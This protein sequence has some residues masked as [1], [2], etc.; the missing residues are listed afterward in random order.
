MAAITAALST[1]PET[2]T[3][4]ITTLSTAT[5]GSPARDCLILVPQPPGQVMP[6]TLNTTGVVAGADEVEPLDTFDGDSDGAQPKLMVPHVATR[7]IARTESVFRM[8]LNS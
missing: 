4:P 5:P 7:A 1:S 6:S 8:I 3:S 2:T